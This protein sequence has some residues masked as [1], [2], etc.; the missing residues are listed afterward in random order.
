MRILFL[1]IIGIFSIF[2]HSQNK[3]DS[4][5]AELL[6]NEAASFYKKQNYIKALNLSKE[7]LSLSLNNNDEYH[8]ALS[9]NLI[10]S[11]YGDFSQSDRALN[12]YT[13][14]LA[15]ANK[16]DND[17][18]RLWLNSNIG[19]VYYYNNIDI[20]ESI[21]FYDKSL[22]LAEKVKD[23][24]QITFIRLNIANAY[25]ELEN[26]DSGMA[27]IKPLSSY[28]E[29]S[30][31]LESKITYHDLLAKYYSLKGVNKKA[32][33]NFL[34]A[35]GFAKTFES[36]YQLQDVYQN[37]ANHYLNS[38]N[39]IEGKRYSKLAKA[40]EVDVASED[41]LDTIDKVAT[42]IEL[43]EYRFQFERI[44]IKNELQNQKIR[45]SRIL[46]IGFCVILIILLVL[47]YSL[48]RNKKLVKKNNSALFLKNK[49]LLA[50]KNTAEEHSVLKSQFISTVS[51]ELRTPL[52]GVVG[53]SNIILE[54]N[55]DLV[56]QENL[57]SLHFSAQYL[58]AL[59]NDLLDINKVEENKI[60]LKKNHFDLRKELAIINNS[61]TFMANTNGNQLSVCVDEELPEQLV[62]DEL[63]LSQIII[64]LI[65]N[66]LK[67]TKNGKVSIEVKVLEKKSEKCTV[68]FAISDTG[69]GIKRED[70]ERIFDKFVQIE[71]KQGDYL[72]TGLGLPI[73]KKL[74]ELFNGTISLESEENKG[75]TFKFA[76][77]FEYLDTKPVEINS[78]P[79]EKRMKKELHILVVEDNKINQI[80][81]KKI[82]QRKNYPCT[83]AESGHEAIELLKTN[84]FDVILM[85]ISMPILDG[86]ETS[87]IIREL[88]IETPIIA[89]TAFERGEVEAKAK[90]HGI[91]DVII[92]PFNP[93]ILFETIEKLFAKSVS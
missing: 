26:P 51:H 45:E 49:E 23:S 57:H 35:I 90:E 40:F 17:T 36:P 63:R 43:D 61:M 32:E 68:E 29:K 89:L 48:Y 21:R 86:Y 13:K 41:K 84:V 12:F 28:I 30:E 64:N 22:E 93:E 44:E 58:L 7:A 31:N 59:V 74:V 60:I 39:L 14:G 78:T 69:L 50:A 65:S 56:N 34:K 11:I 6:L 54:E 42:Q 25:F 37:F 19:G 47:I 85:D 62:G 38:G 72:G 53:L 82:I 87:K 46:I 3:E 66:A 24:L 1:F 71:R 55:K 18:L 27:Y 79:K 2:S 70:Q 91:S 20:K 81:T 92:K 10:G 75:T 5:K 83:I 88:G 33:E 67:F 76:I 4:A 8:L 9:Y 15:Y 52:Y 73:V 16:V 80:V 77:E